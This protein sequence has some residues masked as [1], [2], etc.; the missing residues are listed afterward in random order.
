LREQLRCDPGIISKIRV[1]DQCVSHT[2]L[3]TKSGVIKSPRSSC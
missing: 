2:K 1:I 3:L